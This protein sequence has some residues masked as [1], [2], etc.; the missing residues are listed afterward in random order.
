MWYFLSP[1]IY[2]GA[3]ALEA[4]D[5]LQ[6]HQT[7]IVTDRVVRGLGLVEPVRRRLQR[8]GSEVLV[9]DDAEPEPS[10]E[11]ALRGAA[12]ASDFGPDWLVGVGGGSAMDAAKAAWVPYERPDLQPG[13]ISPALRLDLRRKARLATVPTTSGTGSEV[14]MGIVLTG[15]QGKRK[16]GLGNRENVADIAIVD[17]ALAASMPPGLT[18]ETGLDAL[19]H[20]VEAYTCTWHNDLADG[21]A[22]RAPRFGLATA[23]GPEFET[24]AALGSLLLIDDLETVI[25]AG[26]LCNAY[27]LDTISCGSTIG[28][29]CE[30][31]ARGLVA[32]ADFG[33]VE[34][35]YGDAERLPKLVQATAE[36]EGP[37]A[38]LALGSR[39]LAERFGVPELAG[40]ESG[41]GSA[42]RLDSRP[43]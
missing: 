11:T 8:A 26:H 18:A 40:L 34:I 32:A 6:A 29:A 19:V 4:L 12:V 1:R 39:A 36:R 27:G 33:G 13:A 2:F 25:Y 7:L 22:L 17:P 23:D 10:V 42:G 30:L 31:F 43:G 20:A 35:R 3:D 24:V 41:D 37:G 16:L 9:Y 5:E 15:T 14:T 38:M 28:L 21:H